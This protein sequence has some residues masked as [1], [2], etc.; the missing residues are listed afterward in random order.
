M[1]RGRCFPAVGSRRRPSAVPSAPWWRATVGT[2]R[3]LKNLPRDSASRFTCRPRSRTPRGVGGREGVAFATVL[4][5][6]GVGL[7]LRCGR[8][9]DTLGTSCGAIVSGFSEAPAGGENRI[10]AVSSGVVRPGSKAR[11]SV[12]LAGFRPASFNDVR[13]KCCVR[14]TSQPLGVVFGGVAGN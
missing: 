14:L 3:P 13:P 9:V 1:Y 8:V 12:H 4:P 11:A 6:E 10:T 7:V 2:H 5:R